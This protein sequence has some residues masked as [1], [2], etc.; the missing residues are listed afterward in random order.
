MPL[1]CISWISFPLLRL[2][3]SLLQLSKYSSQAYLVSQIV[4][5]GPI[6]LQMELVVRNKVWNHLLQM[7]LQSL[8]LCIP[9]RT[10]QPR[11]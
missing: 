6:S 3:A 4:P 1:G 10:R 5:I 8:L 9:K 11:K 7:V 2:T